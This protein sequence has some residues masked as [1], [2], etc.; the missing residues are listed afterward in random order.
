ML[1]D[2]I[3]LERIE[4]EYQTLRGTQDQ[5]MDRMNGIGD[6]LQQLVDQVADNARAIEANRKAIETNRKAIE[7]NRDEI[8]AIRRAVA[9]N[10]QMLSDIMEH[11]QVPKK[12]T[13]FIATD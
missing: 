3:R 9:E 11:L 1:T 8:L 5:L 12:R 7:A 6:V 4:K 10:S 2:D 13:G